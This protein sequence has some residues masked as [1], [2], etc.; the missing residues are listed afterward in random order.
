MLKGRVALVTG[1]AT[2]IGR[3]I[4]RKLAENGCNVAINYRKSKNEAESLVRQVSRM[5]VKAKAYRADVSD[6]L[7]AQHLVASVVRDHKRLDILVN[8]AGDW[9]YKPVLETSDEEFDA[10]VR[11][12]LHS[13]FYCTKLS[14]PYLRRSGRGRIINLG[15]VGAQVAQGIGSMGAFMA[16]K[17]GIVAFTKSVALEEAKAKV[18]ANVICPGIIDDKLISIEQAEKER[19]AKIP[20]GRPPTG[21]DIANAVLYL[22]SDDAS[23]IT[24][25]VLLVTGGWHI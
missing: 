15:V 9:L 13:T 3:W 16:A 23:F 2:G 18:T 7:Q 17:A 19:D 25:N 14:L 6:Q 22:A 8:N 12:N 5:G 10:V 20:L 11:E 21:E 24:G 4:V 1:S